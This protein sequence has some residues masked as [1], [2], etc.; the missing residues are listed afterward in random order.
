MFNLSLAPRNDLPVA[1]APPASASAFRV[2]DRS[3]NLAGKAAFDGIAAVALLV[4]TAPLILLALALVK[5][6]SRG[7]ALYTQVRLGRGGKPFLIFKIRTMYH[8]CESLTGATWSRPGD[9]RITPLG[10]WLR[11]TH[12]DELPQLWNVLRGEMS[13]VGPRPERPEFFPAL[14]HAIPFYRSRLLV[15]PGVTGYAQVQLPPDSDFD[16]VR[17]KLAYDLEYVQTCSVWLDVRICWATFF[18]MIGMSFK[19]IRKLFVFPDSHAVERNYQRL[20]DGL[21]CKEEDVSVQ[22]EPVPVLN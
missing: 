3:W 6:T 9:S 21:H 4:L 19:T 10:Y 16:S 17:A 12:I 14:E 2:S 22:S 8:E 18:K 13:L 1:P 7:P 5:W 20:Q 15:R 11:K